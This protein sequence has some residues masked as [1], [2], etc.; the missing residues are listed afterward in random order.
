MRETNH[1]KEFDFPSCTIVRVNTR[2]LVC[3]DLSESL[4]YQ[5]ILI[6]WKEKSVLNY[7]TFSTEEILLLLSEIDRH[8]K[9]YLQYIQI[10]YVIKR[11][12][13]YQVANDEWIIQLHLFDGLTEMRRIFRKEKFKKLKFV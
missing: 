13:L 8:T 12:Y 1:Y 5:K 10:P 9:G 7:F 4:K 2:S 6:Q 3:I 11:I